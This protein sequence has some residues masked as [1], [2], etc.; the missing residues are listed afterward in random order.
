MSVRRF[1]FQYSKLC[2]ICP[3]IRQI[4][5]PIDIPI[6]IDAFLLHDSQIRMCSSGD[7]N[8]LQ[9]NREWFFSRRVKLDS[10]STWWWHMKFPDKDQKSFIASLA[11]G[12][13][14]W[15][16][17]FSLSKKIYVTF[18]S[19][20]DVPVSRW[21]FSSP[22]EE[23]RSR[24]RKEKHTK[25][26]KVRNRESKNGQQSSAWHGTMWMRWRAWHLEPC[27]VTCNN[28]CVFTAW[29]KDVWGVLFTPPVVYSRSPSAVS[30]NYC[31]TVS[32]KWIELMSSTSFW[33]YPSSTRNHLR[34]KGAIFVFV[35]KD[36][37]L[38]VLLQI[39]DGDGFW[40]WLRFGSLIGVS[41]VHSCLICSKWDTIVFDLS[42]IHLW[43]DGRSG[44]LVP[45]FLFR[46]TS[47]RPSN[48]LCCESR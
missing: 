15:K 16:R 41:S 36:W 30:E 44:P 2:E 42:N 7:I 25:R 32:K 22:E 6:I 14:S 34:M 48:F 45:S 4:S 38:H 1:F 10:G 24:R 35:E 13:E 8:V 37:V 28:E 29:E 20:W 33:T 9:W 3:R 31:N 11:S 18:S 19:K 5:W 21:M 26:N 40:L 12:N 17:P 39:L 27:S 43:T 46:C 23:V 47:V